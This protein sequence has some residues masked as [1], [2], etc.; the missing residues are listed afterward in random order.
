MRVAIDGQALMG[1]L[2]GAGKALKLL[3][4]EL[5][6]SYPDYEFVVL[7]PKDRSGWRL[8][9]QL[10]W[11]Q[12]EVPVAAL[13]RRAY[14][15]HTTSHSAP[16]LWPKR[17]VMTVHDLAPTRFPHLLPTW[18][19][20]WYWG[21]WISFTTKWADAVIVPSNSTKDDLIELCRI[22]EEKI[23][24]VPWGVTVNH[25]EEAEGETADILRR[26][27]SL[28]RPY[29]LYVGTIDRRKDYSTLLHALLQIDRQI[30]LVLAGSI[31]EG[32]TDFNHL[33]SCLGLN[34][35]VRV[36]GYVHEGDLAELYRRAEVFIYPSFYEGFG[37]PVLESMAHGTP[38]IAY[39]TTSLPEVVGEAG[40]LLTAP[41]TPDKLAGEIIRVLEDRTL[42]DEL[43]K[44]GTERARYFDW[45][46]TARLTMEVYKSLI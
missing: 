28:Q 31:I 12:A 15:L 46:E 35:R 34:K 1:N 10:I 22:P 23:H 44:R 17:L 2:T 16:I 25:L 27:Y 33:V 11:D 24:V 5:R 20:R 30:D 41:W 45:T 8:P 6:E 7:S 4:Q 13:R 3:L 32:R 39:N 14:L 38:V 37:L 26:R 40:I 21:S 9:R 42:K 19:S 36:L 29:L 18:R 43:I